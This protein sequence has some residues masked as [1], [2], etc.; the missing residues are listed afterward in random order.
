VFAGVAPHERA[1][2][3]A[4]EDIP[5]CLACASEVLQAEQA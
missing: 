1:V 2:A 3:L 5:S 4:A